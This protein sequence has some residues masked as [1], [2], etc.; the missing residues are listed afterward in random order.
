MTQEIENPSTLGQQFLSLAFGLLWFFEKKNP[1][2]SI[3]CCG[4]E[5]ALSFSPF[6]TPLGLYL[7]E[8][9]L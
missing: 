6:P 5:K 1:E 2:S 9:D 4:P 3:L 8:Q 7:C